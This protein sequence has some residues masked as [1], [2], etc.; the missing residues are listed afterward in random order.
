MSR[1]TLIGL[2]LLVACSSATTDPQLANEG[3]PI[4]G[5]PGGTVANVPVP[6]GPELLS[7]DPSALTLAPGRSAWIGVSAFIQT[8][9]SSLTSVA[10]RVS[11]ASSDESVASVAADSGAWWRVTARRAGVATLTAT[12]ERAGKATKRATITVRAAP[13]GDEAGPVYSATASVRTTSTYAPSVE[14]GPSDLDVRAVIANP[15]SATR[16][17]WLSGCGAWVGVY[18]T[19]D[20]ASRAVSDAPGGVQCMAGERHVVL[21]PGRADT[22]QGGGMRLDIGSDTLGTGRYHVVASLDRICCPSG[23]ARS[24]S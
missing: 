15:T 18:R 21:A 1:R 10:P 3:P 8:S 13:V 16:D 7:V 19:A 2:T 5:D 20:E 23:R 14:R 12:S 24:T 4:A 11:V 17:I 22:V 9:P 6:T